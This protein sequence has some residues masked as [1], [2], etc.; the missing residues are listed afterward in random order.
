MTNHRKKLQSKFALHDTA[1]DLD[2]GFADVV[3]L[4]LMDRVRGLG[5]QGNHVI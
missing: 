2:F 4:R 5:Q 3:D 1:Q